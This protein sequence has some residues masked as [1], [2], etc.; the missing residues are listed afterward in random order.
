MQK[1]WRIRPHEAH[2]ISALERSAG[3]PAVLAQLLIARGVCDAADARC[4]LEAKLSGLREPEELP[5]VTQAVECI[6][7]AVRASQRIY[8]Y[9]D[10]DADGM[11]A[12]AILVRCLRLWGADVHYHVPNRLEDGYGLNAEALELIA[13]RGASL[14]ITVDCG[15]G[16]VAEAEAARRLGLELI[17]TDHHEP[18]PQ[19]PD[20]AAIVHPA[21]PGRPYPFAGLC[22]AGVAF[23]LA[24][25]LCQ[26][27]SNAK[28]VSPE[29]R[30][31]LIGATGLAAVGAVAD[32]VPLLDEN[33]LLV[34]AGLSS[35]RSPPLG[36]ARLM[37]VT[38]LDQKPCWDADDIA[39][40]L[41]P[42]LNAAG[43]LGQA[44]L[45]IDLLTTDDP[46][47]A[48][49]LARY[50]HQLNEDRGSIERKIYHAANKQAVEQYEPDRDPAL[51]LAD[52]GWHA[53]VIG[54]VA[55]RLA[56]KYNRPVVMLSLDPLG[57]KPAT[58]S[59]RSAGA[60]NLYRALASCGELLE[61]YGGHAAAAGLK[62]A[63][64]NI[65]AFR[66]AFCEYVASETSQADGSSELLIDAEAPLCQLTLKTVQDIERLAP[67]G[68]GNPRPILCA[69]RVELAAPPR[70]IGGGERHLSLKLRQHNLTMRAVGFNHGESADALAAAGP[71][72]IA[73]RPTINTFRNRRSVE[74]Q[75]VD[76]RVGQ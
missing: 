41:A 61:G 73:Y 47:R 49:S 55:G 63:E 74:M 19:L 5:G 72:D 32:V 58:G 3:L 51:V 22:G 37:Q 12:A 69:T 57:V 8:V 29:M 25:A 20:A 39:F 46:E 31:F 23:K 11:T 66:S 16:S 54:I 18:G 28:K 6:H 27:A 75:L 34:R 17:I 50:I 35:L 10:Y 15:I 59:A 42:R 62:V 9:G 2:R 30:S 68:H 1:R 53:G 67:F 45:G 26:R 24:W 52:R 14:V 71:L 44:R 4:F 7:A 43:R 56:E 38:Q 64:A 65:D 33:R 76:W 40:T 21:L 36:L 48:D 60:C 13:S 70:R